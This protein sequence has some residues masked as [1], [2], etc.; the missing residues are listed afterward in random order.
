M[1]Q[2]SSTQVFFYR[3]L[4]YILLFIGFSSALTTI[5]TVLK[6]NLFNEGFL[7]YGL[8]ACV[9]ASAFLACRS[10][11]R[12]PSVLKSLNQSEHLIEE[13]NVHV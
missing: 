9:A 6:L 3:M 1:T 2:L 12:F 4:C 5:E 7:G 13:V 11:I 8:L 10:M